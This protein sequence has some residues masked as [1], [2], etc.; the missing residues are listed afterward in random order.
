[1][2]REE[3]DFLVSAHYEEVP[4]V[5]HSLTDCSLINQVSCCA[6]LVDGDSLCRNKSPEKSQRRSS[7]TRRILTNGLLLSHCSSSASQRRSQPPLTFNHQHQR[8]QIKPRSEEK[9]S[10]LSSPNS[11]SSS[12]SSSPSGDKLISRSDFMLQQQ[13][14]LSP[15]RKAT[16]LKSIRVTSND[17]P[18]KILYP[19]DFESQDDDQ[20]WYQKCSSSIASSSSH[21]NKVPT[22]DSGIVID[23]AGTRPTSKSS[24]DDVSLLTEHHLFSPLLIKSNGNMCVQRAKHTSTCFDLLRCV[25]RR[26]RRRDRCTRSPGILDAFSEQIR[27]S[28]GQCRCDGR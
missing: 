1:M 23:T 10:T 20:S 2:N 11:S 6:P 21:Q 26:R 27:L 24:N 25:R 15:Q 19:I 13:Q 16:S 8:H 17:Q 14:N 9:L 12:Q 18:S 28:I 22:S 5:H 4:S 3:T 7:F